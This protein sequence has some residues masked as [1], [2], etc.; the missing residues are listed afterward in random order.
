M[1]KNPPSNTGDVSST[2]GQGTKLPH[3]VGQPSAH[4]AAADPA[5]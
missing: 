2:A 4:T 1:V 3:A 5:C